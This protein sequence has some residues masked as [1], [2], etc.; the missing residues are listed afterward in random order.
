MHGILI[1][2]KPAGMTSMAAV[3][4]VR[5]KIKSEKRARVGH[6]GTLDPLATGVLVLALGRATACIDRLMATEK[7]YHTVIDLSAFTDTD[8]REAP[9]RPVVV[10]DPPSQADLAEAASRFLGEVLQRPPAYS[11]IKI[12]GQRAY[13]LARRGHAVIPRPRL[14]RVH[15][16]TI[17]H[18]RWPMLEL[19][20]RCEKG[21]YVRSLAR[22]L[23]EALGTGGHCASIRR[24]AVGPFTIDLARRMSDLPEHLTSDVVMPM[25]RALE[26]L[27]S[28]PAA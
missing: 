27:A 12:D 13:A 28:P 9:P 8:D 21:F 5:R 7:R 22:D 25:D 18:Y 1:L 10:R 6:A 15:G 26:M 20:I 11:A 19:D 17:V 23:G 24:T 2:D 4:A 16:L 3:S 14:V